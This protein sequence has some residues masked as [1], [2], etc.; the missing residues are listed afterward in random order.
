MK[1]FTQWLNRLIRWNKLRAVGNTA[2]MRSIFLLPLVGYLILFNQ[3][4]VHNLE[5][6]K[7]FGSSDPLF[8]LTPANV[9]CRF[10]L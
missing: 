3:E 2:V 9:P 4:L 1:L 8:D 10:F 5:L 6:A 7:Q